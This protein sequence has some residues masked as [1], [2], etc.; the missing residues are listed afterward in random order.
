MLK[1]LNYVSFDFE[2]T[3][4]NIE[5]DD[6]IQVWIIKFNNHFQITDKFSS[7][8]KPTNIIDLPEIVEFTTWIDI[9]QLKKAPNFND[10]KNSLIRFFDEKTVLVWHNINFDIWFMEKYLWEFKYFVS[11]DTYI[12]SKLLLHFEQ[13]YALEIL[14]DKYWFKWQSHDALA[15]SIM[16]MKL[17][18]III[19]KLEKLIWKYPFLSDILAE[20]D[21]IFSKICQ[22]QPTNNP[23]FSIPKKWINIPKKQKIRSNWKLINSYPNKTVFNIN[24]NNFEQILTF[25]LN[26]QNK[27]ILSFSSNA[28]VMLAKSILKK[29]FINFSI[30]NIWSTVNLE[31][32]K[33]LLKKRPLRDFEAH[34]ILKTFSHYNEN[35]SIFDISNFDEYKVHR[36]LSDEQREICANIILTT[37]NELF[38][39]IKNKWKEQLKDYTIMFFDWH[40][41]IYSLWKVVNIWFD[42][43]NLLNKLEIISYKKSFDWKQQEIEQLI[44]KIAIFFWWL[45]T[46]L[47]PFFKWT[48]NK[49]EF[50]SLL[51]NPKSW[52]NQLKKIY[53]DITMEIIKLKDTEIINYW[54]IFKECIENY[55]IIEQKIF[56]NWQLKYIFNP[57]MENIDI[58]TFNE[59]MDWL[60]YYNFTTIN[61]NKYITLSDTKNNIIQNIFKDYYEQIS[62]NSLINKIKKS[63]EEWKRIFLVSNNKS[64]S[65]NLFKL[66]FNLFKEYKLNWNIYVENIT[67]WQWKLLYYLQK[68]KWT[69]ITIWWPEFLIMNKSKYIN[70]D[71]IHLLSIWWKNRELIKKDLEFYIL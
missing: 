32:E 52:L 18:K 65:Q 9:S 66:I 58:N 33:K 62:F 30:L 40:Y 51:E 36:F 15:D 20:S 64:F 7:Y 49:I 39:F 24:W 5:K 21:S 10:I 41:R 67:W 61:D 17:F 37:H 53:Q 34:Y 13:S 2:T 56:L 26:W 19:T 45:S 22:I 60:K 31:N 23:V 71:E 38:S 1:K 11:F 57:L 48:D 29:K 14:A 8:I 35:L 59:Y 25:S 6:A 16:S 54:N 63:I 50:V 3:W 47:Q 43:Y 28:R 12:Y 44:N 46:K 55:C 69:R 70:Y 68:D 4:L 27:T 42:F